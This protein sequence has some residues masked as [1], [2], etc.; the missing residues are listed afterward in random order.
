M[1]IKKIK[2]KLRQGFCHESIKRFTRKKRF[3]MVD[4]NQERSCF[5]WIS[6]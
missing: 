2:K 4:Y 1:I 3:L 6:I 5:H